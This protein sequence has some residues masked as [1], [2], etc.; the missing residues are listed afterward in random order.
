MA[1]C[2]QS[3]HL[4]QAA[5]HCRAPTDLSNTDEQVG[6]APFAIVLEPMG[7]HD[8]T[9]ADDVQFRIHS[10]LRATSQTAKSPFV[11]LGLDA[12]R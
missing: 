5:G 10:A 8:S 4:R 6:Q 9:V 3:I 12:A 1:I 11:A 2:V 7:H